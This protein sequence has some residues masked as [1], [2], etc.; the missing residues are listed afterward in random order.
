MSVQIVKVL[1]QEVVLSSSS[2]SDSELNS[3]FNDIMETVA[4]LILTPDIKKE[5]KQA[6]QTHFNQPRASHLYV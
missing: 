2:S 1:V 6:G 5:P 3:S 4:H